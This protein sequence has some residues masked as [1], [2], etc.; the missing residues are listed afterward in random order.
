LQSHRTNFSGVF[1]R[2]RE[3]A[4]FDQCLDK[5]TFGQG[6]VVF[7]S[8]EAG[9]GKTTL[10]RLLAARAPSNWSIHW[11]SNDDLSTPRPLSPLLDIANDIGLS[12]QSLLS[13]KM[14][15]RQSD[16]F[17]AFLDSLLER[18]KPA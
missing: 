7:V 10:L 6:S 4:L 13:S 1:E 8:G 18:K 5:T 11:G 14:I 16:I 15:D 2:E 9:I 3:V 12:E 17:G